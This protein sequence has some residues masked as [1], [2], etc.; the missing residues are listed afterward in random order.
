MLNKLRLVGWLVVCAIVLGS[1]GGSDNGTGPIV[2]PETVAEVVVSTPA[3]TLAPQQTA[4]FT[5]VA[6]TSRGST[7]GTIT[8]SWNSSATSVATVSSSGL[9]TGVASGSVVISATAGGKT[10]SV[11]VTITSGT[12]VLAS[13]VLFAQDTTIQLGQITQATVGGRDGQNVPVALGARLITWTSLNGTIATV[14]SAGVVTGVGVGTASIRVSVADGLTTR[15]AILPIVVTSVPGAPTTARVDMVGLNFVPFEAVVKVNGTVSFVF[16]PLAHNVIWD[17]RLSGAPTDI[18]ITSSM[19]VSRSF[20]SPGVFNYT[21]TIH[22]G[23][24]GIVI[25]SP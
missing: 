20:T 11:N 8:P 15:T 24:D 16:P 13:V 6:R 25:V 10:G 7:I 12:G 5:A 17:R 9:V 1:C 3:I 4:Q 19:T 2:N 14:S 18:D 23:M 22:P 21:C